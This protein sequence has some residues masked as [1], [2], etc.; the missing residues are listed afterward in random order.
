MVGGKAEGAESFPET[1]IREALEELGGLPP[2]RFVDHVSYGDSQ[3]NHFLTMVLDVASE[4]RL[5]WRPRLDHEHQT[6]GWFSLDRL[7]EPLHPGVDFTLRHSSV[8]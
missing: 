4:A 2:G 7:P 8:F 1:A 3:G 6:C 5:T